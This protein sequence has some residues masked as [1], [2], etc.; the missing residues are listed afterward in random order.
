MRSLALPTP[1]KDVGRDVALA[2]CDVD[3][4]AVGIV[5]GDGVRYVP[6]IITAMPRDDIVVSVL[7]CL[8]LPASLSASAEATSGETSYALFQ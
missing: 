8:L 7:E 5:A 4:G 6:G 2:A 3:D 1:C